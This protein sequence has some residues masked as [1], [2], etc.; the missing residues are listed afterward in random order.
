MAQ[1]KILEAFHLLVTDIDIKRLFDADISARVPYRLHCC[2]YNFD[3]E[4]WEEDDILYNYD[5]GGNCQTLK[6]LRER[7]AC[8]MYYQIR[9]YLRLMSSMTTEERNEW[10][11]E[12]HI[13][14]DCE[15]HVVPTLNAEYCYLSVDWL[16]KH[17]FDHRGLI[18]K[19]LALE[20]P[21][22]MYKE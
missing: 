4:V 15:F 16:D 20:A 7:G 18:E 11:K 13:E 10:Y 6:I 21:E 19:G 12:S 17:H 2:V 14:Y 3:R 8:L 9:P 1:D 5:L 22:G